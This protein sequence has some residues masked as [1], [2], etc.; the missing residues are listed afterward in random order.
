MLS[1]RRLLFKFSES[2]LTTPK[3]PTIDQVVS[4]IETKEDLLQLKE[5]YLG[6]QIPKTKFKS[7][8]KTIQMEESLMDSISHHLVKKSSMN[9]AKTKQLILVDSPLTLSK[10][11]PTLLDFYNKVLKDF[12]KF[13][14]L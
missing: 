6:I 3:A 5:N 11:L 2:S 14:R 1:L 8:V 12:G 10:G 4:Q 9:R 7:R 13:Q